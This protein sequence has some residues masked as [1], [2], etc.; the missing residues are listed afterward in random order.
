MIFKIHIVHGVINVEYTSGFP[1]VCVFIY[2][3]FFSL[4]LS[5]PLINA[6]HLQCVADQHS[7][8]VRHSFAPSSPSKP[9]LPLPLPP[10]PPSDEANYDTVQYEFHKRTNTLPDSKGKGGRIGSSFIRS[11]SPK[12]EKRSL[13]RKRSGSFDSH[14]NLS[15]KNQ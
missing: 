4:S 2:S 7:L 5:L 8:P 6:T 1:C 14:H 9:R 15:T 11:P 12:A 3:L 13:I 10:S